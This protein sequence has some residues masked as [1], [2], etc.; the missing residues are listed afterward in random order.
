MLFT[1]IYLNKKNK[2]I[3]WLVE[4]SWGKDNNKGMIYMFDNWFDKYVYQVIIDKKY[5][6]RTILDIANKKDSIKLEPWD[7]FGNVAI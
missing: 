1:G 7:R 5:L 2:P 3:K 4:N 6:S